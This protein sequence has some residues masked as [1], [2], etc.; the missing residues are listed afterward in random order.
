MQN[1]NDDC[2]FLDIHIWIKYPASVALGRGI[3]VPRFLVKLTVTDR[4]PQLAVM[5]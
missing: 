4:L 2:I 5:T 3:I 1:T